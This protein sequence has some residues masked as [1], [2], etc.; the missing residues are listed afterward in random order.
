MRR[1]QYYTR[2]NRKMIKTATMAN[3]KKTFS[4]QNK[5][6]RLFLDF[7]SSKEILHPPSPAQSTELR[8]K[9][10]PAP[11]PPVGQN[12][13]R[14]RSLTAR[15]SWAALCTEDAG[16]CTQHKPGSLSVPLL[17][18]QHCLTITR[19]IPANSR[20]TLPLP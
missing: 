13:S 8:S 15:V 17:T 18:P 1:P 7:L 5:L 12:H 16:A 20:Q 3:I 9:A 2:S 14:R 10:L 6:L 19:L 4:P 11:Q